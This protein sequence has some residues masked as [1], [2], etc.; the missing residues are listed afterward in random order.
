MMPFIC[1][2]SWVNSVWGQRGRKRPPWFWTPACVTFTQLVSWCRCF[3]QC[4]HNPILWCVCSDWGQLRSA[5]LMSSEC[6]F[7]HWPQRTQTSLAHHSICG[8]SCFF[9]L[10]WDSRNKLYK[11]ETKYV[12]VCQSVCLW[13]QNWCINKNK[14]HCKQI[15]RVIWAP[16]LAAC[17]LSPYSGLQHSNFHHAFFICGLPDCKSAIFSRVWLAQNVNAV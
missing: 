14:L 16:R 11:I 17:C 3:V 1:C 8:H 15:N 10:A 4:F 12:S 9:T 7:D 5:A 2:S 13:W 6:C